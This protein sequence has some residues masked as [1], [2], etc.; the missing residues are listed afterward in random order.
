VKEIVQYFELMFI[1]FTASTTLSV[2]LHREQTL[3]SI[4]FH[5]QQ[6]DILDV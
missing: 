6:E 3:L 4:G 5:F 1:K 2:I